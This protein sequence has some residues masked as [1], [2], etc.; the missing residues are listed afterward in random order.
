MKPQ[1]HATDLWTNPKT[2]R[3]RFAIACLASL[4]LE[5]FVMGAM[6][7]KHLRKELPAT[8]PMPVRISIV[9][10]APPPATPQPISQQTPP[11]V[12]SH[13]PPA[14]AVLPQPTA[15]PTA[16]PHPNHIA[17][18]AA[19][20]H[21]PTKAA[22]PRAARLPK[23]VPPITTTPTAPAPQAPPAP[24]GGQVDLFSAAIKRALQ[25]HADALY[26][27]AAQMAREAGSPSLTFTY[28]NGIVTGIA[29]SVS[30]GY[31]LLDKAA[32]EDARMASYPPPPP[33][34][35]GRT[36][37]ITVNVTFELPADSVDGD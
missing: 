2:D 4:F 5:L 35:T 12:P 9:S 7:P 34:F 14:P 27:P 23:S 17:H 29:L 16:K 1:T 3:G 19:P 20:M 13:T 11:A 8:N 36:Y 37:H 15:Q 26:P 18:H 28:L 24:T 32:L 25:L 33:G 10:P 6:L 22:P 21:P 30:S 31:P